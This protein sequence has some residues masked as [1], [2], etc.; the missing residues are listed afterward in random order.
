VGTYE[1][2]QKMRWSIVTKAVAWKLPEANTLLEM[3]KQRDTRS[4][5]N[6]HVNSTNKIIT[7]LTLVGI[8]VIVVI[9][10]YEQHSLRNGTPK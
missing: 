10:P 8:E 4:V 3:E 2:N 5:L 1:L 7:S 9:V 6:L